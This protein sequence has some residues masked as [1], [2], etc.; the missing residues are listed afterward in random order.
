[1]PH[2]CELAIPDVVFQDHA[3]FEVI[4]IWVANK[5]QVISI[6]T[7]VWKDPACC[8]MMLVDLMKHVSHSYAKYTKKEYEDIFGRILEG[9]NAELGHSTDKLEKL[10]E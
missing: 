4:R 3:A 9:F 5:T 6:K 1:M 8:G 2:D 10:W 7:N